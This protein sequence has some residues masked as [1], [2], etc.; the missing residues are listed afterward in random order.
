MN[1]FFKMQLKIF[2]RQISS[3]IAA[4]VLSLL[5]IAIAVALYISLKVADPSGKLINSSEAPAMFRSFM[6]MFG[7]CSA[8]MT[9]AFAAQTLFYKYK[10]EGI[11]YVM[12]S[13]PITRMEIYW[14]TIFASII[15]VTSQ[16]FITSVGYLIGTFLIPTLAVKDKFLSWLVYFLASAL[17]AIIS[18]GIGA[19]GHNFVQSK[20]YQFIAGWIPMIIIMIL[21]FI[22]SP[23]KTKINLISPIAK[24]KNATVLKENISEKDKK[25]IRSFIGNPLD[26]NVFSFPIENKFSTKETFSKIVHNSNQ[27]LYNKIFW[28]DATSYFNSLFFTVERK[29][30]ISQEFMTVKKFEYN[31]DKFNNDLNDN[32]FVFKLVDKDISG[33]D[34]TSYFGLTF[35]ISIL[36]TIATPK[37]GSDSI[38]DDLSEFLS[39][40]NEQSMTN[41]RKTGF[42]E[43]YNYLINKL[44]KLYEDKKA[45]FNLTFPVISK[46]NILNLLE[47]LGN[48]NDVFEIIKNFAIEK[49]VFE[50]PEYSKENLAK[51][52]QT[53][54]NQLKDNPI[55]TNLVVKYNMI[56]STAIMYLLAKMIKNNNGSLIQNFNINDFKSKV[57]ILNSL[58]GLKII[59]LNN[60]NIIEFGTKR[61]IKWY[62]S[63]LS[64]ITFATLLLVVGS[65]IYSRKN[66][67]S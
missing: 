27:T 33:N 25:Y 16:I 2:Y 51:Y 15:C 41:E 12:Q 45:I 40:S 55:F 23:A 48:D 65:I 32:K 20:A 6:V 39:N 31:E 1:S 64:Q 13:K 9:S 61:T 34:I 5:N 24:L 22:S 10:E 47:G 38:F 57:N 19:I 17:I 11:Y 35:N 21:F 56:K 63:I 18:I 26:V 37:K 43:I 30:G 14:A 7:T 59:E 44:D 53:Q 4:F 67:Y 60:N 8:F 3:Y 29:N 36:S 62:A 42:D 50:Q 46:G 66:N 49:V 28:L 58:S 54:M 52:N